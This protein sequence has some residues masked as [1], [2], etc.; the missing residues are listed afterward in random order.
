MNLFGPA[1]RSQPVHSLHPNPSALASQ[2]KPG[3]VLDW[4][5]VSMYASSINWLY[6]STNLKGCASKGEK[7]DRSPV[8]DVIWTYLCLNAQD[9]L[10]IHISSQTWQ[11]S[12]LQCLKVAVLQL[13]IHVK[14]CMCSTFAHSFVRL[15][16]CCMKL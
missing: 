16:S 11:S 1:V 5:M 8:N 3:W 2:N 15:T 10:E 13:P 4:R 9:G 14:S 7:P 6:C 12:A